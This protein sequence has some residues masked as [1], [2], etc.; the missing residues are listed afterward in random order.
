MCSV[1]K[2]SYTP[3]PA[4]PPPVQQRK[5]AKGTPYTQQNDNGETLRRMI[6]GV[7][8]TPRGALQPASVGAVK[9]GGG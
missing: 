3:P 8:T 9:L 6:A 5:Q 2:P 4:L 1:K 7:M